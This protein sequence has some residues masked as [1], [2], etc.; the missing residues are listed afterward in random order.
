M[1]FAKMMLRISSEQ[2]TFY[3]AQ[4]FQALNYEISDIVEE[5]LLKY[6]RS[7]PLFSHQLIWKARCEEKEDDPKEFSKN[8]K[9]RKLA[10]G[11][12][13]KIMKEMGIEEKKFWD[14]EDSFFEQITKISSALEPK[15]REGS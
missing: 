4:I 7:S 9:K 3:L 5:F 6:S 11:L 8:V 2:L 14:E 1:Y 13:M 15:V 10:A 12:P